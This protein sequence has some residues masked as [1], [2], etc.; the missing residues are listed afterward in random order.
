MRALIVNDNEQIASYLLNGLRESGFAVDT[1]GTGPAAL[2]FVK[3][4]PTD[5]AIVDVMIP[6]LD[7]LDQIERMRAASVNAPVLILSAKRSVVD[8]FAGLQRGGDDYLTK[9][10]SLTKLLARVQAL[11]R[12]NANHPTPALPLPC[13]DIANWE[14]N[15]RRSSRCGIAAAQRFRILDLTARVKKSRF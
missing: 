11:L 7:G 14:W 3:S 4:T 8:R 6:G 15:P 12:R 2:A 10:F 13:I 9:P 5:I 1:V